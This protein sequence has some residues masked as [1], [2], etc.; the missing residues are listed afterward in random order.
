VQVNISSAQ[1]AGIYNGSSARIYGFDSQIDARILPRLNATVGYQYAHGRYRDFPATGDA[2]GNTTLLTPQSTLSTAVNYS[3]PWQ[4]RDLAL[5]VSW[6]HNSGF[7]D[8]PDNYVHSHAYSLLNA[9][10]TLELQG[11]ASIGVWGRNLTDTVTTNVDSIQ[12]IGTTGI[13]RAIYA[14]PRTY[15]VTVGY[16]F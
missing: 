11:G 1:G 14:P 15:G 6:Y 9:S 3:I 7:F 12:V 13:R 2:A 16:K 5:N 10:A 4:T 8:D